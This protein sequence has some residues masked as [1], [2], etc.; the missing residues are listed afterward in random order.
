MRVK[1]LQLGRLYSRPEI[2]NAVG[3]SWEGMLPTRRGD[4]K[5]ACGCFLPEYNRAAPFEI[6]LGTG[7]E[8]R[9][10]VKQLVSERREIP[11]F[12]RES[13]KRWR[14]LGEF[15][16][17]EQLT[18]PTLVKTATK[19]AKRPISAVLKLDGVGRIWERSSENSEVS[20]FEGAARR[21]EAVYRKREA[22]FRQAKIQQAMT[23]NN[24]NL[25]CEV[26]ECGFDFQRRYGELGSEFAEVHHQN[27]VAQT[28]GRVRCYLSD[29]KIVCS[30]CHRMIH[31]RGQNRSLEA[32]AK[33]IR[34][35][36]G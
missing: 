27:P 28:R 34:D 21:R 13:P 8:R 15:R 36:R 35:A 12:L 9:P 14:Y 26:S 25:V 16:V 23:A 11:L 22:W 19:L 18:S 32:V 31:R 2:S 30:N 4:G 24:G 6:W 17:V 7:V 33:A 29:L 5:V 20:A 3:G 1:R 10:A